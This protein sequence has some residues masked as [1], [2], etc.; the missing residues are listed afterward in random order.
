MNFPLITLLC[1]IQT[2]YAINHTQ[3]VY[4]YDDLEQ[5]KLFY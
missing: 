1:F 2:V 4:L 3:F 5:G